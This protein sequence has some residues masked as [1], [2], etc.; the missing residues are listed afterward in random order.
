M[1]TSAEADMQATACSLLTLKDAALVWDRAFECG[2]DMTSP[3][4]VVAVKHYRDAL[5][6]VN[7]L[8]GNILENNV[9][10][11]PDR[12][13]Y[14]CLGVVFPTCRNIATELQQVFEGLIG[15]CLGILVRSSTQSRDDPNG[16]I[17]QPAVGGS[18]TVFGGLLHFRILALWQCENRHFR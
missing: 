5:Q 13:G 14:A 7:I 3:R 17:K 18:A 16:G 10:R 15:E 9:A 6:R 12:S 2:F 11:V 1:L 4:I 8:T